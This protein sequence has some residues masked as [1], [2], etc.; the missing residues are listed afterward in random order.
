VA[1]TLPD[2]LVLASDGTLSGT[3]VSSGRY[4]FTVQAADSSSI[5]FSRNKAQLLDIWPTVATAADL[6]YIITASY[7]FPTYD[8][9]ATC[10]ATA[11][12]QRNC[13]WQSSCAVTANNAICGDPA[14]ELYKALNVTYTCGTARYTA[15]AG[16]GNTV[17]LSC[18]PQP[19]TISRTGHGSVA[20]SP[21]RGAILWN[22]ATGSAGY[23]SGDQITLIAT[24]DPEYSFAG[25]NGDCSGSGE[26]KLTMD[27]A[28]TVEAM[29]K[30]KTGQTIGSVTFTPATLSVG[31][32][33]T[34]SATAS[35]GL[36]VSFSTTT[37]D[38]CSVAGDA[39]SGK[40]AGICTIVASQ[41][42]DSSWFPAGDVTQQLTVT[43]TP[44]KPGDCDGDGQ[45]SIAE[46]QAAIN[47]YLGLK[48]LE[49]CVDTD[50][51]KGIGIAEVQKVIN[52]Y[53]GL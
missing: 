50:G 47:M 21:D 20:E 43:F 24:A 37:P 22:G 19:L 1:G 25:W 7:G 28:R 10:D 23:N 32:T 53:L 41:P 30:I 27:G 14:P 52:S 39:V 17:A 46:V 9:S 8:G 35:S 4:S 44:T 18:A 40:A 38:I 6:L 2:G 45:V 49:S 26:C 31:G 5:P 33:T 15:S 16:E 3:P 48:K 11:S 42:G 29:F 13:F 34:V 36:P 51:I 12:L